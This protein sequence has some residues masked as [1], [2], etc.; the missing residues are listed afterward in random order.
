MAIKKTANK[1]HPNAKAS[2]GSAKSSGGKVS[3]GRLVLFCMFVLLVLAVLS[4]VIYLLCQIPGKLLYSNR[5]FML[6]RVEIQNSGY[7]RERN[8]E[9]MRRCGIATGTNLFSIDVKKLRQRTASIANVKNA[10]ISVVLPD[11]LI[12]KLEERTPL[13]RVERDRLVDSDGMMFKVSES[14]V[15]VG[16]LPLIIG[17]TADHA[18]LKKALQLIDTVN[19]NFHWLKL[20]TINIKESHLEVFLTH[21]QVRTLRVLFPADGDCKDLLR[22]LETTIVKCQSQ[23]REF[24]GVDLR[25]P[26]SGIL[27]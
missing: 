14:A 26:G 10:E 4:G 17:N 7:W 25:F 5:R 16:N 9:F 1:N 13:A 3:A 19:R 22:K 15:E 8:D 21:Q 23:G 11:K 12:F 20:N 27:M 2:G 24:S 6:R 18:M